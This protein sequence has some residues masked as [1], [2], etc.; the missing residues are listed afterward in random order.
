MKDKCPPPPPMHPEVFGPD[1]KYRVEKAPDF[2][3]NRR[4]DRVWLY[5]IPCQRGGEIAG[6]PAH[7]FIHGPGRLAFCG[8]GMGLRRKLLAIPGV[9]AHQ[10]GDEEFSVHFPEAALKAVAKV[11]KPRTR[12]KLSP[13]HQARLAEGRIRAQKTLAAPIF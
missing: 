13:E 2:Y 11:V 1:S 7:I 9:E 3:K 6:Q 12:R 10:T 4:E 5:V 8:L